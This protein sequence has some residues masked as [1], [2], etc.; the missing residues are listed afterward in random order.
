LLARAPQ[1]G[2]VV[3]R[4]LCVEVAEAPYKTYCIAPFLGSWVRRGTSWRTLPEAVRPLDDVDC[5][6]MAVADFT[7]EVERA[8]MGE[9]RGRH[10]ARRA[11]AVGRIRRDLGIASRG[12]VPLKE[13]ERAGRTRG[14]MIVVS[15]R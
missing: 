4:R 11:R 10:V 2:Y 5:C 12:D 7:D 9:A 8:A 13:P 14:I 3:A 6:S 15:V 1:T